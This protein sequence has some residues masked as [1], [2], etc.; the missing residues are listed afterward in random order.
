MSTTTQDTLNLNGAGAYLTMYDAVTVDKIPLNAQ[1]AAAYNDMN[2]A[3]SYPQLCARFPGLHKLGRLVPIA[4]LAGT[5]ARIYDLEPGNPMVPADVPDAI[6]RSR[7]AGIYR[8]GVYAEAPLLA[9]CDAACQAAGLNRSEYVLWLADWDGVADVTGFD[10]AK[11][12]R[13]AGPYDLSVCLPSFFPPLAAPAKPK[14]PTGT[15]HV[16]LSHDFDNETWSHQDL[17]GAVHWGEDELYDEVAVG[18]CRGGPHA[19]VW[20]LRDLQRLD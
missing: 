19:G 17:A 5:L 20:R 1:A 10:A 6:K 4:V 2:Y 12:F 11:Q 13:N 7:A 18:V 3:A 14:T 8:P 16:L 9:E 15:A